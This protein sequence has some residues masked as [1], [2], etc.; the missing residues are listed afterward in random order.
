MTLQEA[1]QRRAGEVRNRFLQGVQAVIQ[2]QLRVLAEGHGNGF[3]RGHKHCRGRFG[4][5]PGIGRGGTAT[6]LG[7]RFGVDAV[8]G[9]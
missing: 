7:H 9:G 5:H 2:G 1:V 6:P 8:A 4:S 3:L